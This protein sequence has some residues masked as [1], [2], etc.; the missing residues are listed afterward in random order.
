[1][2]LFKLIKRFFKGSDSPIEE[3]SNLQ[4]DSIDKETYR[5]RKRSGKRQHTQLSWQICGDKPASETDM[6]IG[7]DLGTSCTKVIIQDGVLK[8]AYAVPFNSLIQ[9]G[10]PYLLPTIVA[11]D[12]NGNLTLDNEGILVDALKLRFLQRPEKTIDKIDTVS[13]TATEAIT[14][15][16]G[17]VLKEI[18]EWFWT[19]KRSNYSHVKIDWQLNIGMSSRSYDD[20]AL[21][22]LTKRIALAG[23]NL[24][25]NRSYF[26]SVSDIKNALMSADHQIAED[27]FDENMQQLHPDNVCPV[28]EI[29]AQVIGYVRSPMRQNGMY[30]IID[31]GASTIDVSNFIIHE[32]E[33]EDVYTILV[34][35][36]ES[37]GAVALYKYRISCAEMIL[38]KFVGDSEVKKFKQDVLSAPTSSFNGISPPPNIKKYFPSL[39]KKALISIQTADREFVAA[40]SRIVRKVIKESMFKRNPNSV[41]W[42]NGLPVF[43]CGG[44]SQIG[45]YQAIIPHA[46][47]RLQNTAFSGFEPKQLP[48]PVNLETTDIPPKEY[49]RM[50]VAYGL[51]F[52][53]IDIG[54]INPPGPI[55]DLIA[56]TK[57]RDMSSYFIDKDMV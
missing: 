40:C 25:L 49:H 33:G 51:S 19:E 7:F 8:K 22:D 29:I 55:S 47:E 27:T 1:M 24:S 53:C 50:S 42:Q 36:V 20:I 4:S 21:N 44:G 17:L 57:I 18:R 15:Y 6:V 43:L 2:G 35:E 34:A 38:K 54:E 12:E 46:E 9:K 32:D 10:N 37:L 39:P 52:P 13:L 56:D 5:I 41:A 30:L 11:V 26:T 48:R 45:A 23:W 31:I 3:Y 28:P 16:I 14:A